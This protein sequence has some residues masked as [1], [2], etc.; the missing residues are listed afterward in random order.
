MKYLSITTIVCS[1][2]NINAVSAATLEVMTDQELSDISGQAMMALTYVAPTDKKNLEYARDG[3]AKNIGFYKFGLEAEVELNANI[4]KLQLGC[5]A[6]QGIDGC[7]IDIDYLSLS[8]LGNSA[9]SNTMSDN[10]R[11]ARASSS[12]VLTNPFMEFAIRNPE[13]ASTREIAGLRFSAEK[14]LGL[15]TF[16][17]ENATTTVNGK[18]VG[19]PSGI[20]SLSG[21]M[22]VN[23]TTGTATLN[24]KTV[25]QTGIQNA[26]NNA[27][28]QN[29]LNSAITGRACDSYFGLCGAVNV[30]FVS[31]KYNLTLTPPKSVQLTL[32]QQAITGQRI[33]SA[34]LIASTVVNGIGLSGTM[35]ADTD[36]LGLKLNDKTV[37]GTVNNLQVIATIDQSLGLFHKASLNGTAV[38]LS[39]Q[40][41]DIKWTDTVSVAK[42]GWWME[43]TNPIDIG[44][45]TPNSNVDISDLTIAEALKTVSS[46]LAKD[47]NR[48]KCGVL[49]LG[50]I[51]GG[52]DTGKIN[53]PDSAI[54]STM[55]MKDLSLKY[56]AFTPNCYGSL[57]FC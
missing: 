57:K 11:N 16:G 25:T 13:S 30:N 36:F 51:A 28:L 45:I 1:V 18:E 14:A 39:L 20:N 24:S 15:I 44:N 26:I 50:C 53:L 23:N 10:D 47:E 8:G 6:R 19:V 5:G 46:Y 4:R 9:T 38:S 55:L 22:L 21:Y 7:D 2:F 54:P 32:G 27:G 35:S 33:S 17:L 12:A 52:I 48:V 34:N 49:A 41:S 29:Q 3:G 40:S 43:F 37:T 56:Q 31:S 42:P